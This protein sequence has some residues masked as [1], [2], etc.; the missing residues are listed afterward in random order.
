M[1]SNKIKVALIACGLFCALIGLPGVLGSQ[2]SAPAS[3]KIAEAVRVW[4]GDQFVSNLG[5]PDF[6]L[7]ED[8]AAQTID[9]LFLIDKDSVVRKE[10]QAD[11]VPDVSRKFYLLF[12]LSEY[13]PQISQA[14]RYF[15]REGLLPGDSL[16]IQ[17]PIKNYVLTPA[18]F[19]GKSRE[20]L[21]KELDEIVRRDIV[22]GGMAYKSL[23]SDLKLLVRRISGQ[24]PMSHFD[25][26]A[27]ISLQDLSLEQVLTEY[28]ET[29]MRMENLRNVDA[30]R[31]MGFAEDLKRVPGQKIVFFI[32]QREFSPEISPSS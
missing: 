11:F 22:E 15:F 17:T 12:Q 29:V 21:A 7:R 19:A 32:Y 31:I 4:N 16:N 20:V 14:I 1:R 18:A 23:M 5:L 25:D 28:R 6:E 26:Q 30:G 9:A 10:G 24:N 8:G 3:D 13:N 27:G 2:T